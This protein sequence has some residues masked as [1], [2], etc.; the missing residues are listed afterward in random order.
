MEAGYDHVFVEAHTP[1]EDDWTTLPEAGGA[2]QTD[3]PA[4]CAE[5]GF[6]LA[7]HP[8]LSH[9][10]GGAD[11]TEPGS[12]GTWNSFT[13]TNGG[14]EEVAFDLTPYAGQEV[15]L[16]ITYMTDP[17]FGGTGVFVDDTR[18]VIDG[19]ED[20]DGFEGAT[21]AWTP[22][23][24]RPAARRTPGSGPSARRWPAAIRASRPK[25]PTCSGSASSSCPTAAGRSCSPVARRPA[26]VRRLSRS[27][28][29]QPGRRGSGPS[30]AA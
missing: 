19:V 10:F 27:S 21:S 30:G 28:D 20:A 2:T 11:C 16:S 5:D 18:V 24:R 6:L 7:Q 1:G 8:F 26:G 14:W 12:S 22:T 15:E 17:A 4:E 13:G 23:G 25:T 9:Y 3:P 29:Q